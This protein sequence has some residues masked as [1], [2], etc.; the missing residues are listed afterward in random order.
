MDLEQETENENSEKPAEAKQEVQAAPQA[1]VASVSEPAAV[2]KPS[3][4]VAVDDPAA[5]LALPEL[6]PERAKLPW[7]AIH[8]YAGFESRAKLSLE[9]RVR[10]AGLQEKF[11]HIIV[12]EETVVE[13][14]KGEKKT[15]TRKLFPSYMLVQ[16]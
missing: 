4:T 9:E 13:L 5:S 14:Q 2:A 10:S 11:G 12:P 1:V 6:S 8:T 7:Y 15:S 3:A 16:L